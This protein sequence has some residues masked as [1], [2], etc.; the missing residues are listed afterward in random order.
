MP[1]KKHSETCLQR[2]RLCTNSSHGYCVIFTNCFFEWHYVLISYPFL[3]HPQSFFLPICDEAKHLTNKIAQQHLKERSKT[4][5]GCF[6]FIIFLKKL[7]WELTVGKAWLT[8]TNKH[9]S[10]QLSN[11]ERNAFFPLQKETS[12]WSVWKGPWQHYPVE[13]KLFSSILKKSKKEQVE[14]VLI[15][16]LIIYL[17]NVSEIL[18]QYAINIKNY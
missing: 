6:C 9:S 17:V 13:S 7:L 12:V 5:L 11:E 10:Y 2:L 3:K 16:P 15:L 18:F 1:V 4:K 14:L 8:G